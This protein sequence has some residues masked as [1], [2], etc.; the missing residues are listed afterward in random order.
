MYDL[1]SGM[2][3]VEGSAFVAAP[4]GG[5]TLAQLGADVIRFD[6]IGGALDGQRWPVTRTGESLYWASLN[7]GKRSIAVD[8]RR[9]EGRELL[10][11]LITAPGPDAGLFITNLPSRGWNAYE[12]LVQRRADLIMVSLSGTRDGRAQVDYTVNA[13]MGFPMVTGPE[14]HEGPVN[15]VLPA[16][17]IAA[18]LTLSTG[19]LAAERRRSRTGVGS[20]LKL[21][22][23]DVA[24]AA[25][26]T[27]GYVAEAEVNGDVRPRLGNHIFGT[28]GQS[29]RCADGRH[30]MICLFTGRH[31]RALREMIGA[32][33]VAA[34]E[35]AEA[36]DLTD[37]A[38][39]YRA[40]AA[41]EA[42]IG[43]WVV[44]RPFADVA[45]MLENTGALWGPY[46]SFAEAAAETRNHPL[47]ATIDQPGIGS[48]PVPGSP[49]DVHELARLE[50][51]PAP[52]HGQ[53]TDEVLA[54]ILGL[55][56][57]EIGRLHDA[58]VVAGPS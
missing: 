32:D 43:E 35:A 50:P 49:I 34:I 19:L 22:L 48:Y 28:F 11:G 14:G 55:S 26:A 2:R 57:G 37:E 3:I 15:N 52:R 7:K 20:W 38:D 46:R 1:L 54:E 13:A 5:M 51:K 23:Y 10:Q 42:A 44:A 25:T 56:A 8:V 36:A 6:D 40:R 33:A 45:A 47:F 9:P 21:S 41:L 58:G 24:L 16:W 18:A 17:D 12:S 30:V 27:L 53:H 39:R 31:V 4:M 29:F